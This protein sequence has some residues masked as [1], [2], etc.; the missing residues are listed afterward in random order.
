[1]HDHPGHAVALF[2]Q[3]T[4]AADFWNPTGRCHTRRAATYRSTLPEP[5]I[6]ECNSLVMPAL[7]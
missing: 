4:G 5:V 7:D 1:V 6:R 2:T 3:V